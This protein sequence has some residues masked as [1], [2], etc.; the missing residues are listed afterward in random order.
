MELLLKCI[1]PYH[2]YELVN[3][4]VPRILTNKLVVYDFRY[5]VSEVLRSSEATLNLWLSTGP[6]KEELIALSTALSSTEVF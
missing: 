4:V 1:N 3:I 6:K 5:L 2:D